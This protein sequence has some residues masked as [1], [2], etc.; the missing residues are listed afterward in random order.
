M[1]NNLFKICWLSFW[2]FIATILVTIPIILVSFLGSR[3]NFAFNMARVWAWIILLV[4]GVSLNVSGREKLDKKRSYIIISNHQSHFDGPALAISLG[5]Q[6]RWIAKKEL[7]KI[8]VMG[9]ALKAMGNIFIDRS[10]KEIAMQSISEGLNHLPE[11]VGV[12]IFAEGTRSEDGSIGKFKKGGFAAAIQTGFPILP[13]AIS[14]SARA[15]PKNGIVF[16]PGT[17]H[18][19]IGDPIETDEYSSEQ[20]DDLVEKVRAVIVADY[21]G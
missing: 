6:F 21:L 8:P 18:V 1:G 9:Y 16:N 10:N 11:G 14:G 12:M 15:L 5:L 20:L 17:I 4:A 7:L 2:L 19:K 3:G 13:V